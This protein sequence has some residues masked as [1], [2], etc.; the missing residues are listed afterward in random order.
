MAPKR[1]PVTRS[2]AARVPGPGRGRSG[3]RRAARRLGGSLQKVVCSWCRKTLRPGVKPVT[4]GICKTCAAEHFPD[5]QGNPPVHAIPVRKFRSARGHLV[6]GDVDAI[7]YVHIS[8][9][10]LRPYRQSF[11]GT[12]TELWALS[13]GSL[14]VRNP[15]ARLWED[16]LVE[17]SE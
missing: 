15:R 9:A 5:A 8:S 16:M 3:R 17:D 11:A 10:S 12:G 7:T 4:H 2:S 6:S 14:L 1:S 13:D